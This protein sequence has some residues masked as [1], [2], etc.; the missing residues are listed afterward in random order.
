MPLDAEKLAAKMWDALSSKGDKPPSDQI[1]NYSKGIVAALKAGIVSHLPGTVTGIT[2]AGAPLSAGAAT[3]GLAVLTPAPMLALSCVGV[4]PV[5]AANIA[6]ENTAVI[7]YMMTGLINFASGGIT[8]TCTSTPV[9]P[10]PLLLGAGA[11][12]Q[13]TMLTGAGAMAAVMA[14]LGPM[15]PDAIGLYGAIMDYVM[16]EAVVTYAAGTVGGT[17]P[18]AAGPLALGFAAGGTIA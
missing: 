7:T 17:C 11:N 13:I 15:G 8:G 18:A 3:G 2:A 4:P 10:G 12:G 9:A 5:A 1:K 16:S 6:K 14:A